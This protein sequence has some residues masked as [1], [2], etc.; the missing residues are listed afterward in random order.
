MKNWMFMQIHNL[1]RDLICCD[2]VCFN[3]SWNKSRAW[4]WYVYAMHLFTLSPTNHTEW[5]AELKKLG[6]SNS[7]QTSQSKGGGT[8]AF[9]KK[10][11]QDL[12]G[13]TKLPDQESV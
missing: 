9:T 2:A 12:K 11:D 8:V 4:L 7:L 13:W 6:F 3:Y 1:T 10:T 5:Q